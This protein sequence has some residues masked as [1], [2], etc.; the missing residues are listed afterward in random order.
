MFIYLKLLFVEKEAFS[1]FFFFSQLLKNKYPRR[2]VHLPFAS[3]YLLMNPRDIKIVILI[4]PRHA[5]DE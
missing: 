3:Q 1:T 2:L 5:T 4:S